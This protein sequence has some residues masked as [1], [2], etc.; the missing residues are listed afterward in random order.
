MLVLSRKVNQSIM[1]GDDIEIKILEIRGDQVRIGIEA[2]KRVPV[3][4]K[5]VYE[6][7]VK[8][9][10]LAAQMAAQVEEKVEESVVKELEKLKKKKT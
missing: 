6:A 7:I 1:I 9:N 8:E 5:E 3:H 10:I 2:P 4:R